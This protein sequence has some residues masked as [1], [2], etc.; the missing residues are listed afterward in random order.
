MIQRVARTAGLVLLGACSGLSDVTWHY[1][2]TM[3]FAPF[4]PQQIAAATQKQI[5]ADN[6]GD[7]VTRIKGDKVSVTL[8][9]VVVI[10]DFSQ[11]EIILL[12]TKTKQFAKAHLND[13]PNYFAIASAGGGSLA[14]QLMQISKLDQPIVKTGNVAT[15]FGIRGEEFKVII[16]MQN[17]A[18]ANGTNDMR[19][20]RHYWVVPSDEILRVPGLKELADYTARQRRAFD[21]PKA[22]GETLSRIFTNDEA[23]EAAQMI[24]RLDGSYFLKMHSFV[25]AP[26]LT[27]MMQTLPAVFPNVDPNAPFAEYETAV[28]E[29]STDSVPDSVFMVPADYALAPFQEIANAVPHLKPV[30][31]ITK[32]GQP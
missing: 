23:L 14:L 25:Y 4:F 21:L 18:I 16:T 6:M 12:N 22:V 29:I 9:V 11:N 26:A 15:M 7:S 13:Y 8:G 28:D 1:V 2:T 20:E 3:K 17:P 10:T 27:K 5:S 32:P 31:P 30:A 19:E 24:A